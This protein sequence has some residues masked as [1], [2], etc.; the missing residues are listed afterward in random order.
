M[1]GQIEIAREPMPASPPSP[2]YRLP[3]DPAADLSLVRATYALRRGLEREPEDMSSLLRLDEAYA[4]RGMHEAALGVLDRFAERAAR[5]PAADELLGQ[6]EPKRAAHRRDLGEPPAIT[7]R[8]LAEL[9]RL[10]DAL[11]ATGRAETAAEVL[12]KANP[13]ERAA[14]DVLDRIATLRLY[15][16]EPGRARA[17]W[18]RGISRAP[19]PSVATARI[20]ATYLAEEDFDAAR[21]AYQQA[22]TG[23]PSLFEA[24]Y[25]LAVLEMDAGDAAAA[26]ELAKRAIAAAPDDRS[27]ASAALIAGAVERFA[28]R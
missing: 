10:V 16:G 15:L 4:R 1:L 11:M 22:L 26:H 13:P 25:G 18:Q 20:G 9:D 14:W 8:N 17:L 27:R 3:F 5:H 12:E 23:R 2:R 21:K 6:S 19:D 7:W 28:T 24:C